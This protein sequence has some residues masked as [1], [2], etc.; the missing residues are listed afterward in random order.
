MMRRP[1]AAGRRTARADRK[2]WLARRAV[3]SRRRRIEPAQRG[4]GRDMNYVSTQ[5][6]RQIGETHEFSSADRGASGA[7]PCSSPVSAA[8]VATAF[9]FVMRAFVIDDWGHEFNLS[10]TQKGELLGVGLWPFAISIV[11]LSLLIDRLGF[12]A[13]AV[14]RRRV[15]PRRHAVIAVSRQ[16]LLVAVHRHVRARRSA[17]ALSKRQ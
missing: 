4:L 15:S 14:V 2:G 3:H 12:R 1:C 17:T 16:R 5:N 10:A 13:R 6:A 7:T 8:L 11:L 9:C